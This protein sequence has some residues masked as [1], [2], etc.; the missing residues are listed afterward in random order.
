[1]HL[2]RDLGPLKTL[3]TALYIKQNLVDQNN[4]LQ[5]MQV[6]GSIAC[7]HSVLLPYLPISLGTALTCAVCTTWATFSPGKKTRKLANWTRMGNG[8][9]LSAQAASLVLQC[10]IPGFSNVNGRQWPFRFP[11]TLIG[12]LQAKLSILNTPPAT[13]L[14]FCTAH[15]EADGTFPVFESYC[16]LAHFL[17]YY[18]LAHFL[19]CGL[20]LSPLVHLS[21]LWQQQSHLT[22]FC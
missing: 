9:M 6:Q 10:I 12:T 15:L 2:V 18:K 14:Q 8:Q 22:Q 21:A 13:P 19:S 17:S 20:L 11:P 3:V 16:R 1:M 4:I 7:K 5:S